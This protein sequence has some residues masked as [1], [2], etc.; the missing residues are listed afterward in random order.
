[1]F[2]RPPIFQEQAVLALII[3]RMSNKRPARQNAELPIMFAREFSFVCAWCKVVSIW[4]SLMH[5]QL[6]FFIRLCVYIVTLLNCN[7][8]HCLPTFQCPWGIYRALLASNSHHHS[9][10]LWSTY[11]AVIPPFLSP[12][13]SLL[14]EA[15]SNDS[16]N[17]LLVNSISSSIRP[18]ASAVPAYSFINSSVKESF[19]QRFG[20]YC[21][22]LQ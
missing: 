3:P 20:D 10:V 1:M 16:F 5:M 17:S 4:C 6:T 15:K 21:M 18:Y 19:Q 8:L 9:K 7:G 12:G 14:A 13:F 22:S 11:W 2:S